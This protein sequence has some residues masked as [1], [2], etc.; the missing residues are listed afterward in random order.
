MKSTPNKLSMLLVLPV[1][2]TFSLVKVYHS[3]DIYAVFKVESLH[4][5]SLGGSRL[6][7][8][9]LINMLSDDKKT[10]IARRKS[11]GEPKLF[12]QNKRIVL[13]E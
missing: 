5:L 8:E 6:L 12:N 3:V 11:N 4:M 1:F 10:T 13:S 2:H 9:C 7:K